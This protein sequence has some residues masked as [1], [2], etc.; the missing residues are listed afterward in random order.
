MSERNE[1]QTVIETVQE[2]TTRT[3]KNYW[4]LKA[5]GGTVFK[6]WSSAV[7][8]AAGESLGM[9]VLVGYHVEE[10]QGRSGL[11]ADNMVDT[12]ELAEQPVRAATM[13]TGARADSF[14]GRPFP[15][16]PPADDAP[17][18]RKDWDDKEDRD[19]VRRLLITHL[20][21]LGRDFD[22]G[23]EQYGDLQGA[24][25]QAAVADLEWIRTYATADVPF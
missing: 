8:H 5:R 18:T 1:M 13:A 21:I 9:P 20:Q 11:M 17:M 3:N 15:G 23:T 6:T 22:R 2:L 12:L 25:R 14:A 7:A 4:L 10:W 16:G 19:A 24:A